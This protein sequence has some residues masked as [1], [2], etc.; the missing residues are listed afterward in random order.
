MIR[1]TRLREVPS[2]LKSKTNL[3][4]GKKLAPGQKPKAK[5]HAPNGQYDL[6]DINECIAKATR[7]KSATPAC[8]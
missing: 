5:F 8:G 7:V 2:N 1:Y 6:Y 3:P 4:P